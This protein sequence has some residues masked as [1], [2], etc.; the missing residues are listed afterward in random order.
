MIDWFPPLAAALAVSLVS[1]AGAFTLWIDP[2]RLRRI[3]PFLVSLAVGV[4]LGDAFLHLIPD[5]AQE[6][7]SLPET[8][9]F[10]LLGGVPSLSSPAS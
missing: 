5:A 8:C 3:V 1:L 10:V 2:E 7:G 6:I 9:L 4:L